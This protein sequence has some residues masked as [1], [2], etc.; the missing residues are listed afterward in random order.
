MRLLLLGA[1]GPTGALILDRTLVAGHQVTALVRDPARLTRSDPH[2]TVV[3]GDATSDE[4]TAR[5][6]AGT[7]AALV[8]LGSGR[9]VRSEIA[10]RAAAALIPALRAAGVR[11]VVVLSAFGVGETERQAHGLMRLLYRTVMRQLFRDKA[12]ADAAWR[13]S[14][15]DW[16]LVY[17]TMLT[18]GPASGSYRAAPA[19]RAHGM[20][21]ISRADVADF[22]VAQ[23]TDPAWSR[24]TAV[25][26]G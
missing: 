3:A 15:L 17:P 12:K 8:A 1:T 4:D 26:T 16:T 10:T 18:N 9:S 7:E 20:P 5:A 6:A 21:R 23:L 19:L 11:R 14:G 13:A 24:R 22:M 2:L 25:L